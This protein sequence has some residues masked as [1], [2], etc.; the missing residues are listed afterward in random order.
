MRSKKS[1]GQNFLKSRAIAD[2]LIRAAHVVLDENIVE[3]GPG[4]GIITEM[5]VRE[6]KT[7]IAVEKDE[8]MVGYLKEKFLQQIADKKLV[9]VHNDILNFNPSDYKLQAKSYKLIG[10]IP[11]YI[12]GAFLKKFLSEKNHPQTIALIIQ[13]EV[14]NRIVA[15]NK[16]ESILSIS[17]KAYGSPRYVKTIS[18]KFFTPEPNVDSAIIAIEN[19]SKNF[20]KDFS[21]ELFFKLVKAGFQSKRKKVISNIKKQFSYINWGKVFASLTIPLNARA[22]DLTLETWRSLAINLP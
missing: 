16:K 14:A 6:V 8:R 13:K 15:Q 2:E 3:V 5:L 11:Y 10:S 18:R 22:E 9:L 12:T 7:I 17:V 1:L 19:I 4:K 20:F 21:E